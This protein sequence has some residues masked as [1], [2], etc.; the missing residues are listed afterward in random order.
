MSHFKRYYTNVKCAFCVIVGKATN[1]VLKIATEARS[2]AL[3]PLHPS[4]NIIGKLR[5][6]L[7]NFLPENAHKISSGRL[8][9]SLTRVS[10]RKN[11]LVSQFDSKEDLIQAS[12]GGTVL[13]V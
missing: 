6:G 13:Y 10:D 7:E 2:R 11:V 3:G 1:Y 12:M 9:V 8:F 5:D 4:F